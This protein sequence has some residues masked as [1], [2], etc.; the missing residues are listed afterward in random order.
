MYTAYGDG[1]GF[2]PRTP[3]KLSLGV[4]VVSGGPDNW[5]GTNI[6]SPSVEQTGDGRAG[7]KA[8][9]MLMVDGVLYM[10]VRNAGNSQLA[11]SADH[12][13]SWAWCE[14]R[15]TAGFGCPTFLNAGRNYADARD[16]F[17]YVYSLDADTAYDR[18]DHMVLARVPR[19]R[20]RERDAYRFY[21]GR[22]GGGPPR[23]HTDIAARQAVFANSGRCYR[24]SVTYNPGLK[25][26]LW[27]QTGA[28]DQPRFEGGLVI[29]DAPEPW[30]PWTT[31]Y[32]TEHW[33]VGPGETSSLP[34]KWMSADGRTVHLVFSGDDCFA[35]RRA[36]LLPTPE[37]KGK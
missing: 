19:D 9:G 17:V 13:R 36:V 3:Q 11:W 34:C 15:F 8:S 37:Q 24:S 18:A 32:S 35:V 16:D 14:W 6:R 33:D 31:A 23:W 26:Y 1:W 5:R 4:A 2:T 25:R 30:G 12:G 27:C 22:D 10:L 29:Y 28:G 21:G 7:R 20:I